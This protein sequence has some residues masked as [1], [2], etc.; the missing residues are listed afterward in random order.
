MIAPED[1]KLHAA[2]QSQ[3]PNLAADNNV[4]L[5]H[6][7]K[8]W[9]GLVRLWSYSNRIIPQALV[10]HLP[11]CLEDPGTSFEDVWLQDNEMLSVGVKP[12]GWGQVDIVDILPQLTSS[13][14]GKKQRPRS[15]FLQPMFRWDITN[16]QSQDCSPIYSSGLKTKSF[17]PTGVMRKAAAW[18]AMIPHLDVVCR[19]ILASS[20]QIP[21]EASGI[22]IGRQPN[23]GS[24]E[25]APDVLLWLVAKYLISGVLEWVLP[26]HQTNN[27]IA[28]GLVAKNNET[29]P[30][31]AILDGRKLS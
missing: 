3:I 5:H 8:A 22:P 9:S 26:E 28:L 30:W 24:C 10:V 6:N 29:E 21:T 25:E 27:T 1:F 31:C 20:I 4:Q 16:E 18:H 19:M 7:G 17:C 14:E 23:L 12:A 15:G 2:L 11:I 13:V